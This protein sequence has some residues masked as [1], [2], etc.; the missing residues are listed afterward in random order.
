MSLFIPYEDIDVFYEIKNNQ[1]VIDYSEEEKGIKG[2][3]KVFKNRFK[4]YQKY[5]KSFD[6]D[7]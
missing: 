7:Q 1:C 4:F 3:F 6:I 5:L 2:V